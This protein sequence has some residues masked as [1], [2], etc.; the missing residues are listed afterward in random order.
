MGAV[1]VAEHPLI[2][3]KVALKVIH[4]ELAHNRE[5][6]GRFFNE[7]RSVNRIGN[8]HIVDI[9]DFGT[10]TSG[11]SW[12]VMELLSGEG[13]E[14]RLERDGAW[15]LQ[16]TLHVATQIMRELL[17]KARERLRWQPAFTLEQGL[18]RTIDW[19]GDFLGAES[20]DA[21]AKDVAHR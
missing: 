21:L 8:E 12:F 14:S 17:G 1:Y 9:T 15:P 16:R 18:R 19:Y 11:E 13:L 2:G 5:V 10:A 4:K 6:V 20:I 3:K 7:A